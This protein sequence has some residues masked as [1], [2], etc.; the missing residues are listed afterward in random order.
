MNIDELLKLL[1]TRR[2]IRRYKPNP[3]PDEYIDKIIEAVRWSMSGANAQPWG[4]IIIKDP[5]TK[6]KGDCTAFKDKELKPRPTVLG[7]CT[8]FWRQKC[9]QIFEGTDVRVPIIGH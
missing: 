2:S 7:C 4:F 6:K 9:Q 5:E 8:Y 1:K 3:I